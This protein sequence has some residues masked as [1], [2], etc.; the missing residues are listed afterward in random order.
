MGTG[1]GEPENSSGFFPCENFRLKSTG[2][3]LV[4][5]GIFRA[6]SPVTIPGQGLNWRFLM[7]TLAEIL[8]FVP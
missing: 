5:R 2:F 3:S 4:E 8:F 6:F 7:F 1:T